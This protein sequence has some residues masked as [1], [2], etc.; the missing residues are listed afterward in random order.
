[1]HRKLRLIGFGVVA[2]AMLLHFYTA[3]FKAEGG[4]GSFSV[5]LMLWAWLPYLVCSFMLFVTKN[6][7]VPLGGAVAAFGMDVALYLSVFVWPQS[8]TAPIALLFMQLWN[9]LLFMPVGMLVGWGILKFRKHKQHA[10]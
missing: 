3:A 8:S 5:S 4:L 10:F 7:I 9:L 1:M 6:S 2:L